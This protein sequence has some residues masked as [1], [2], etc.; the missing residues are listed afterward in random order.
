MLITTVIFIDLVIVTYQLLNTGNVNLTF[1]RN[2]Y[3]IVTVSFRVNL[4]RLSSNICDT[5][6]CFDN[7]A[8]CDYIKEA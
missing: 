8:L 6:Y 3:H 4:G 2:M 1:S 5:V 7:K